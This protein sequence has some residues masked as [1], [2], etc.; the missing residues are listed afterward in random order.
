MLQEN[1]EEKA[2]IDSII[3]DSKELIKIDDEDE[4]EDF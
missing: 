2:F 3:S 4:R 1:I